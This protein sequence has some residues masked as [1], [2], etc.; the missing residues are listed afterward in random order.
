MTDSPVRAGGVH[1]GVPAVAQ[2]TSSLRQEGRLRTWTGIE[3]CSGIGP[4][5]RVTTLRLFRTKDTSPVRW[6]PPQPRRSTSQRIAL[7]QPQ[8]AGWFQTQG[9]RRRSISRR[10]L[11]PVDRWDDGLLHAFE[12]LD[13]VARF[14]F[15]S[16]DPDIFLFAA[17]VRTRTHE[18]SPVPIPPRS[19]RSP[20]PSVY[21]SRGPWFRNGADIVR[22]GILVR[23]VILIRRILEDAVRKSNRPSVPSLKGDRTSSAPKA[24]RTARRSMLTQAG[25]TSLIRYLLPR[26]ALRWRFPCFRR[27]AP[28]SSCPESNPP[29]FPLP[30]S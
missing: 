28:G 2:C 18:R 25:I 20:H 6:R 5:G 17:Q 14:W 10:V 29:V 13:L 15:D 3:R 26:P 11:L 4:P 23:H 1:R 9:R 19:S 8:G 12:S 30:R 22:I 27:S 7:P 16:E 24:D 21:K